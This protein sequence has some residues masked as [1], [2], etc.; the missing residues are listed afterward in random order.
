M[1]QEFA[2][3]AK[4]MSVACCSDGDKELEITNSTILPA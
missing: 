2:Q 4:K 1:G 3:E